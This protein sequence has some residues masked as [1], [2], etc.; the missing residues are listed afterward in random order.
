M[1]AI[2]ATGPMGAR[3]FCRRG[4]QAT[5]SLEEPADLADL[6]ADDDEEAPLSPPDEDEDEDEDE[7]FS[8]ED[9]SPEDFSLPPDEADEEDESDLD[10]SVDDADAADTA[11]LRL[12]VR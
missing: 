10:P 11:P 3:L 2:S 5:F 12:S 6:A 7:D 9:F 4:R 8:A 1:T